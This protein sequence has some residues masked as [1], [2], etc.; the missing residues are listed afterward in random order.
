MTK[1][2]LAAVLHADERNKGLSEQLGRDVYHYH[3]HVTY[4]P[5]VRKEILWTKKC[6]DKSLI[7]KVKEVIIKSTTLKSGSAKKS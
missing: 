6:K 1:N 4:I 5:V 3:L 2:I 7:G